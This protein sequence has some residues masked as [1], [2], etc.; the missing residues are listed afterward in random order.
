LFR[1]PDPH[2]CQYA[3]T[4]LPSSFQPLSS[5]LHHTLVRFGP[6]QP[7]LFCPQRDHLN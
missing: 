3:S 5:R 6:Q 4:A 2:W 1:I 7:N